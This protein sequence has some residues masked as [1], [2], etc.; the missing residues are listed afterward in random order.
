[1]TSFSVP[2]GGVSDVHGLRSQLATANDRLSA[3][4]A[5][6]ERVAKLRC[7]LAAITAAANWGGRPGRAGSASAASPETTCIQ[8]ELLLW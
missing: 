2:V 6:A 5:M 1:M 8:S 7:S 3:V 4:D